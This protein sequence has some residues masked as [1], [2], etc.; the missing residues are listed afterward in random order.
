MFPKDGSVIGVLTVLSGGHVS[1]RWQ[2]YWGTYSMV[3]CSYSWVVRSRM[4]KR[5]KKAPLLILVNCSSTSLRFSSPPPLSL[6]FLL[7][8]F[9]LTERSIKPTVRVVATGLSESLGLGLEI[10]DPRVSFVRNSRKR[11]SREFLSSFS[12]RSSAT[13]G[14]K[15]HEHN[16]RISRDKT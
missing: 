4:R 12:A 7:V 3:N 2:R 9:L 13:R 5:T 16:F 6:S 11:F 1:K 14:E 10:Y 8:I 15:V